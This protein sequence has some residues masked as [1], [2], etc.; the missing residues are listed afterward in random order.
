[1]LKT[2]IL[3]Q[4]LEAKNL[5]NVRK[6]STCVVIFKSDFACVLLKLKLR[7]QKYASLEMVS[8]VKAQLQYSSAQK[9]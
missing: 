3:C 1:M 2:E 8:N 6:C 7:L 4:E 5:S 9:A